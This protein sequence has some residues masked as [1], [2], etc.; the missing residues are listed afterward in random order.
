MSAAGLLIVYSVCIVLASLAGGA[1]PTVVRLT[2]TRVQLMM[3][4]V[5]GLMLGVGLVHLLPHAVAELGSVDRAVSWTM[6]GLLAMFFLIRM[7]HFHE[8]GTLDT[9]ST[10]HDDK[11]PTSATPKDR[12]H[13]PPHAH[14]GPHETSHRFS[15]IGVAVGM[16]VHSL[17]DGVALAASVQP[18]PD[19]PSGTVMGA[20]F[21]AILLHKPLD[22]MSV[23]MVMAVGGWSFRP[24]QIVNAG[25][26][27]VC[28]LGAAIFFVA[29]RHFTT[30]EPLLVGGALGFSAGVFLC[31]A[32]ADLLPELQFH[33]HDRFK[34]SATLLGGVALAYAIGLLEPHAPHNH[35][36]GHLHGTHG[37][38]S[39]CEFACPHREDNTPYQA[40]QFL[41]STS[42]FHILIRDPS[43]ASRFHRDQAQSSA[44]SLIRQT[45]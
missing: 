36:A 1:L 10:T 13:T 16:V 45:L 31:I 15:W 6:F 5:G 8:H 32:L 28:P 33:A 17:I 26:A 38:N 42:V 20:V 12:S 23:T 43:K 40:V 44:L 3:S 19:A 41:G 9:H 24:M 14:P 30:Y 35:D 34:L 39:S 21:L 7:F 29:A 11:P 18:S 22:A 25:F 2:H 27:L 37:N 4:F